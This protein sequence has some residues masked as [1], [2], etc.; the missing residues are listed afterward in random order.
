VSEANRIVREPPEQEQRALPA[1]KSR[2]MRCACGLPHP[3]ASRRGS[4]VSRDVG[5]GERSEPHRSRASGAGVASRLPAC[6][7]RTMRCACGLPHPTASRRGSDVS[8]DGGCGER[9]ESHRS[10]ASGAGVAS[11]LPACKS[12]TMR[13]ACGLPYPTA[14]QRGF[15][16]KAPSRLASLP[17]KTPLPSAH[18]SADARTKKK[19]AEARFFVTL[20]KTRR[21]IRPTRPR[22]LRR[23]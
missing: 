6:K 14:P 8:R 20:A 23:P 18:P 3:T 22:L 21:L 17:Q 15:T 9:S 5:C 2:M 10:R 4:D 13:C 1:C 11:R 19:R 16:G 7:S 12:R